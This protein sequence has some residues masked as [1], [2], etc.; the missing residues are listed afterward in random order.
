MEENFKEYKKIINH[1]QLWKEIT[2]NP[3]LANVN[4]L[5]I[6]IH[7]PMT[8]KIY[9]NGNLTRKEHEVLNYIVETHIPQAN[10]DEL[11]KINLGLKTVDNRI[12]TVDNSR[13]LFTRKYFTSVDDDITDSKNCGDGTSKLFINH[14]INDPLQK[15]IEQR[16]NTYLND[17]WFFRGYLQFTNALFDEMCFE[18]RPEVSE[19]N[20]AQG[21]NFYKL[22][23]NGIIIPVDGW[24]NVNINLNSKY[25]YPVECVPRTDNG[26]RPAGFWNCDFDEETNSFKNITP[27]P[28]GDGLYNI[29]G[30][31]YIL[32]RHINKFQML[33]TGSYEFDTKD[34]S[35]LGSNL[36]LITIFNTYV[37]ENNPDHEWQACIN[38]SMFR[39]KVK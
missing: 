14:K 31:E 32:K 1:G 13:P 10:I 25:V 22:P 4:F 2:T 12:I 35:R 26:E 8:I 33:G 15:V 16:F 19:C 23:S 20:P 7:H 27:A 34:A 36:R 6:D 17:T 9:F 39:E 11:Y 24:G 5:R 3:K 28:N 21:S 38:M 29:F 18:V 37:D 30:E